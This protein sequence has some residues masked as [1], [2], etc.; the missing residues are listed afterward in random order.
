MGY[1]GNSI[2][3]GKQLRNPCFKYPNPRPHIPAH[4]PT[5]LPSNIETDA[6]SLSERRE[7]GLHLLNS[8]PF[9]PGREDVKTLSEG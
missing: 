5:T 8:L 9:L 3:A 1:Q 6:P 7:G 2:F 4:A